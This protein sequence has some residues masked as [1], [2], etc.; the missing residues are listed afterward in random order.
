RLDY[1][2]EIIQAAF[3]W[4]HEILVEDLLDPDPE[5]HYPVLVASKGAR[6]PEDCGGASGYAELKQILA[7]PSHA[8]HPEMV[9]WLGLDDAS[10]FDPGAVLPTTSNSPSAAPTANDE[11][12]RTEVI[13]P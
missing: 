8:Q 10:E 2:S 13:H 1:L 3:G 6:P 12:R 11:R 7:N 5:L 4:E 9:E